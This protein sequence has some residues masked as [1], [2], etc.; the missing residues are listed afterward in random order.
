MTDW[1]K[2]PALRAKR[3]MCLKAAQC[4]CD[5]FSD[6][7]RMPLFDVDE[8][9]EIIDMQIP[10]SDREWEEEIDMFNEDTPTPIKTN[11]LSPF[12]RLKRACGYANDPK[13]SL[14]DV[15]LKAVELI[16]RA[17]LTPQPQR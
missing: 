8:A 6:P 1:K 16:N 9:A 12:Q 2:Y 17:A 11:T 10:N 5:H 14:G 4:V 7:N 13:V 15:F 3:A